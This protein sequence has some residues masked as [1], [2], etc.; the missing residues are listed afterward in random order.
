MQEL[1]AAA[2]ATSTSSSS[3]SQGVASG[4]GDPSGDVVLARSSMQAPELLLANLTLLSE[5][6]QGAGRQ[7]EALPVLQLARL[8]AL[9][10]LG[11]EVSSVAVLGELGCLH[12]DC[13][14]THGGVDVG[15]ALR[16]I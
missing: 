13:S 10:T 5:Q 1:A 4:V 11:S 8:V 9:V 3:S 6:L 16:A 2:G 7:I 15:A 12:T 14:L